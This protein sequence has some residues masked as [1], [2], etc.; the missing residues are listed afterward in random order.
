MINQ[1]RELFSCCF[2]KKKVVE[3]TGRFYLMKKL[4]SATIIGSSLLY[5]TIGLDYFDEKDYI[6]NDSVIARS[7]PI[8]RG[9]QY[10]IY[11]GLCNVFGPPRANGYWTPRDRQLFIDTF[12]AIL[13]GL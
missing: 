3:P 12:Y 9:C 8:S 6:H 13:S 4:G 10:I 1:L 7:D 2:P 11:N 5:D